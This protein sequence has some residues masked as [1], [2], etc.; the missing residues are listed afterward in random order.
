[1][2][3][4][5]R[6][7]GSRVSAFGT[8]PATSDGIPV[9]ASGTTH[10]KGSWTELVA[11]T[12]HEATDVVLF[13]SHVS[14]TGVWLVDV[15]VGA[16]GSE[17]ILVPDIHI[18][19]YSGSTPSGIRIPIRI[20]S[21]SRISA[22]VQSSVVSGVMNISGH[23][24]QGGFDAPQSRSVIATYGATAASSRGIQVDPGAVAHTKGTWSEITSGTTRVIKDILIAAGNQGNTAATAA[25]WLV[26]VAVGASG[27]EQII[28]PDYRV[29]ASGSETVS[30]MMSTPIP[31][32]ISSG[33]RL[34]IRSQCNITDATD[35]RLDFVLYG[36]T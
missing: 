1:M 9:T 11:S 2:G 8:D 25:L 27:S 33:S 32:S 23:L 3:D 12:S 29:S 28:I 15:G 6:T 24:I 16:S 26:D 34:A 21:G 5:P 18:S 13:I 35:R 30:P 19:G 36:V 14:L 31:V 7:S 22:R 4:W 20:P 10:T 17:R